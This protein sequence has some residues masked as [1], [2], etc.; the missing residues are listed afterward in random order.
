MSKQENKI[1]FSLSNVTTEQFAIVEDV[2]NDEESVELNLGSTFAV[3]IKKKLI[4]NFFKVQFTQ[5]KIPFLILE[6]GCHFQ[7]SPEAW[8][9]FY[10]KDKNK[11]TLPQ[12][13]ASHLVLLNIGTSRGVLH[14]KTE[15]TIFNQFMLPTINVNTLIDKDVAFELTEEN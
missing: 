9:K 11:I 10:E 2:F 3:D 8:D 12:G 6:T 7:I 1:G 15:D 14:C 5:K 13:F 4:T